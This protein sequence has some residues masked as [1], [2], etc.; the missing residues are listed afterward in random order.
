MFC[1]H[2][3]IYSFCL[4]V[5]S[6]HWFFSC[7]FYSAWWFFPISSYLSGN[8][9]SLKHLPFSQEVV[10]TSPF[11]SECELAFTT[12]VREVYLRWNDSLFLE[13]YLQHKHHSYIYI[14]IALLFAWFAAT[15]GNLSE[16]M[17]DLIYYPD[18]HECA[19]YPVFMY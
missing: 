4:W 3:F 19:E 6:V 11:S 2:C 8:F 9:N 18:S 7:S 1:F 10:Q 16:R 15:L 13:H 5:S 12:L 14:Y 17:P